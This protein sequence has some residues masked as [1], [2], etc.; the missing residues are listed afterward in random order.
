MGFHEPEPK[1]QSMEWK[2]T[3]Y[4]VKKTFWAEMSVKKVMVIIYGNIKDPSQ[5]ISLKKTQ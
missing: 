2:H 3:D 5:L 1:R 4:P